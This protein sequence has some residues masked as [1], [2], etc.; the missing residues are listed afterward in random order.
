MGFFG[1]ISCILLIK[2]IFNGQK[3]II[4]L[5]PAVNPIGYR[6]KTNAYI[7]KNTLQISAGINIIPSKSGQI[8]YNDAINLTRVDISH[9]PLE[10]RTIKVRAGISI[11]YEAYAFDTMTFCRCIL[12]FFLILRNF[13]SYSDILPQTLTFW[14]YTPKFWSKQNIGVSFLS[15]QQ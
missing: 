2:D 9:H 15:T 1:N 3:H 12:T 7:R 11:I 8:L 4:G 14:S 10:A 13:A 5:S 6:D